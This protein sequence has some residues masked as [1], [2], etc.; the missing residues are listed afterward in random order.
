M[1][2]FTLIIIIAL[3][4]LNAKAQ[5]IIHLDGGSNPTCPTGASMGLEVSDSLN[6]NTFYSSSSNGH[7]IQWYIGVCGGSPAYSPIAGQNAWFFNAPATTTTYYAY[8][9]PLGKCISYT[10]VVN[11]NPSSAGTIVGTT[12]VCNG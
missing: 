9:S 1:K 7:T 10:L 12:N 4:I 5:W 8:L 3:N 11:Q 2:K 6:Y